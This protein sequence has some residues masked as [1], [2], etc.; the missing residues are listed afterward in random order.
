MDNNLP[1]V[2]DVC[3]R[4]VLSEGRT[5]NMGFAFCKQM[6]DGSFETVQ[7]LSPCKD[8][9]NDVVYS[10]HTGKPFM[11]CGLC[12]KKTGIFEAGPYAFL[13]IKMLSHKGREWDG[14]P[15]AQARLKK[16]FKNIEKLLNYVE[17]QFSKYDLTDRT[18]ITATQDQDLFLLAVPLWW[19]RSTHLI[20]LYSLFVRMAQ[21]WDGEGSPQAFLDGYNNPLDLHLWRQYSGYSA[22]QKYKNMLKYGIRITTPQELAEFQH[23]NVHS[24]GILNY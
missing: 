7:P 11:A 18:S 9:L 2:K 23:P 21:F 8:Y 10:E 19:C 14:L 12:T 22:E 3:N 24:N 13:A 16:N 6:D 20:S 15:E 17:E 5:F 1:I 4:S